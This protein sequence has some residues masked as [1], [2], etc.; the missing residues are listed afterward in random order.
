MVKYEVESQERPATS[1]AEYVRFKGI[2]RLKEA[3]AVFRRAI[4]VHVR[5]AEDFPSQT[6]FQDLVAAAYWNYGTMLREA[7]R[8]AEG[9]AHV[10][11]S[12][13]VAERLAR[14]HPHLP[15]YAAR[16]AGVRR[17]QAHWSK[18]TG[19]FEEALRW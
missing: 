18:R 16:L 3:E 7:G 11:K 5:L 8:R 1:M 15:E 14:E 2:G 13:A 6:P 17:D 10:D 9:D 12:L 4:N 19:R